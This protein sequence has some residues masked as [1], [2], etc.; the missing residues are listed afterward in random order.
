MRISFKYKFIL[1]FV[2]I[3]IIFISIIVFFNF[4]SLDKITQSLTQDKVNTAAHLFDDLIKTPLA[5][6]DLATLDNEVKSFLSI[7]NIVSITLF[8]ANDQ[9][10]SSQHEDISIYQQIL[11]QNNT[12]AATIHL[13][14]RTF[15]IKKMPIIVDGTRIGSTKIIFEITHSLLAIKKNR[16]FTFLLIFLEILFSTTIAYIIG[17]KLTNS[18]N[19]L[20]TS[21]QKIA[22]HDQVLIPKVGKKG[23]EIYILSLAMRIMQQ[24]IIKRDNM[25]TDL[26][27]KLEDSS[28]LMQQERD[29][30]DTLL[31]HA[32]SIFLVMNKQG[33]IVLTNKVIESLTGYTQEELKGKIAWD[34][35]IPQDIRTNVKKVFEDL[36]AG[37]FPNSYENVW[38][39]KDGSHKP[40]AWS[41]SCLTDK[42]DEIQYIITVG[43]DMTEKNKKEQMIK[44]LL[45]SPVDAIILISLDE[46]ILEINDVA[47]QRLHST[48]AEL[49]GNKLYQYTD[50][51]LSTIR[52]Q[53]IQKLQKSK[54][55]IS[56]EYTHNGYAFKKHLY[57]IFDNEGTVIQVSIFST[58]ITELRT[59][60]KKLDKYIKLVDE[61]VMISHTDIHGYVTMESEAFCKFT[62]YTQEELLGK[63]HNI[64]KDLTMP[65]KL[66]KDL[67]KDLWKTI[68]EGHVWR[69]D[70]QNRTKDGKL[71]WVDTNIYPDFDDNNKITGYYAIRQDI[72]SKKLLEELAITDQLTGLYNRRYF[73]NIFDSEVHRAKRDEKV[74]CLL[75]LDI[76]NFK[77]YNDT[78]GHKMGDD[79][80]VTVASVLKESMQRS[81]DFAFRIGG[82]EFSAI[83]TISHQKDVFQFTDDIRQAIEDQ[84]I[85]HEHNTASPYVTVS[86]GMAFI[87][88]HE[89]SSTVINQSKFYQYTDQLLYKAKAAGRNTTIAQE[90]RS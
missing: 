24:R 88:F 73:D 46:T 41:N 18:L 6:K 48:P 23:D 56:F 25:L 74:F 2:T 53:N 32:N 8:D 59:A 89:D 35:F 47:A 12:H 3:E 68:K 19:V 17:Y 33:E 65:S 84:K 15:L 60:Q 7:K 58:D 80:L 54:K 42:N 4:S 29:F 86:I 57:P 14:N 9:V 76:D 77:A 66:Y 51:E 81:G 63:K 10:V 69:G 27:Q 13:N 28:A 22:N 87:D 30:Y 70:I 1:S 67:Y 90:F 26:V 45:N 38:I 79:T 20:F 36:V 50:N 71:Y 39:I 40:F 75:S 5:I 16:D 21:A 82:E 43:I 72:T 11:D 83:F 62:G 85:Q 49:K 37:D 31:N 52:K 34:V 55:P 44:T 78:Y 64:L 61:N